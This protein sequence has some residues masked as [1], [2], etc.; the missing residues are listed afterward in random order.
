MWRDS[1]GDFVKGETPLATSWRSSSGT[2]G[3]SR[4][5]SATDWS[6]CRWNNRG[7][8]DFQPGEA[9]Y[10]WR[11]K[12]RAKDEESNCSYASAA[13]APSLRSRPYE[14]KG[15]SEQEAC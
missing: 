8:R 1:A 3:I 10:F 15:Q 4:Q 13:E 5:G 7:Q 9:R 2:P 11:P 12:H 14:F 6:R